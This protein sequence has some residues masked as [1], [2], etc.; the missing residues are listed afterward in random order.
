MK[1]REQIYGQKVPG[2]LQNI[3][4]YRVLTEERF[5]RL[6]PGK[7]DKVRNL[8]SF[9]T[10]R[11]LYPHLHHEQRP[12]SQMAVGTPG[13]AA[14]YYGSV[15]KNPKK[16]GYHLG[17]FSGFRFGTLPH[18]LESAVNSVLFRF[19]LSRKTPKLQSPWA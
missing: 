6:Y 1:T 9:L 15:T 18:I 7:R 11:G 5:L 19:A 8:L 10:R 16:E 17:P 4:M 12:L 2:I 13:G 3:S 14:I